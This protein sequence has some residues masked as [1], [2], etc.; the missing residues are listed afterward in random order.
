M[1]VARQGDSGSVFQVHTNQIPSQHTPLRSVF[2]LETLCQLVDMADAE[3]AWNARV[4]ASVGRLGRH[5]MIDLL[6]ATPAQQR[7]ARCAAASRQWRVVHADRANGEPPPPVP[8]VLRGGPQPPMPRPPMVGW[9]SEVDAT[10]GAIW[11]AS[12]FLVFCGEPVSWFGSGSTP[13][14]EVRS[15]KCVCPAAS[16]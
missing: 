13:L 4:A 5:A 15:Q 11:S 16:H 6:L 7:Q 8:V 3:A 1:L 2:R 12:P 9:P 10:P 14:W